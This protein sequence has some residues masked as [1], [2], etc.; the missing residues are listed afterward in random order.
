MATT[1]PDAFAAL[2]SR[3]RLGTTLCS[4]TLSPTTGHALPLG[5]R[6]SICGSITTNAA[7]DG[8]NFML[9]FWSAGSVGS[10]YRSFAAFA[11]ETP[12]A[13]TAVAAAAAVIPVKKVRR[14]ERPVDS[15]ILSSDARSFLGSRWQAHDHSV[16]RA[17]H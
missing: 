7:R 10:A 9:P 14:S 11:S 3:P 8:S 5:L 12:V 1:M 15:H 17:C 6:K 4:V 13:A 2:N 16:E